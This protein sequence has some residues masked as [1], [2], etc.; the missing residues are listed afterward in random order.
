MRQHEITTVPVLNIELYSRDI[1]SAAEIVISDCLNDRKYNKC[2]SATGAHGLVLSK[3]EKDFKKILDY[4]YM[5]LPDGTP[6]VWIGR[7]KGAKRMRRCYGPDFFEEVMKGSSKHHLNHF[8]CGGKEGVADQLKEAVRQ[9][10]FNQNVVGTYC[11]PFLPVLE[12]DYRNI[13]SRINGLGVNI[14]W[15]GL[16]TPKQERFAYHLSQVTD[17]NFIVTVGAAFDFHAGKVIQAPRWIQN[18]GLEWLFRLFIEPKRL[19]RRYLEIV[20]G[21]IYYNL[22]E[23]IT[24]ALQNRSKRK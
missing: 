11:P 23:L 8:F 4:F 22:L 15:I 20:P 21:F 10:F 18:S 3:K 1:K 13:A 24:F 12:Y 7:I 9:R 14:I 6:G 16:S 19:F 2:I 17:V 5:N